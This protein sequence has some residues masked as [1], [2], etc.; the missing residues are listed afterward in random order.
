MGENLHPS[1]PT[2][3]APLAPP[4]QSSTPSSSAMA[5]LYPQVF[6]SNNATASS[7]S[8]HSPHHQY[9]AFSSGFAGPMAMAC[10]S[11]GYP[12]FFPSQSPYNCFS[13]SNLISTSFQLQHVLTMDLVHLAHL[14]I[15]PVQRIRQVCNRISRLVSIQAEGKE[16]TI[17]ERGNSSFWIDPMKNMPP[18]SSYGG[19]SHIWYSPIIP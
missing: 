18:M 9:G 1:G 5:A 7:D 4:L 3:P 12:S 15:V 2:P 14:I 13:P 6:P 17:R 10:S 16:R 11:N 19:G 8:Y